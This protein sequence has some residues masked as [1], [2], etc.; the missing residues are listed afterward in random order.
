M[1]M[2]LPHPRWR[3]HD[4][5]RMCIHHSLR[6]ICSQ[7][8]CR[9][10]SCPASSLPGGL[11]S[12]IITCSC[13]PLHHLCETQHA[14]SPTLN[15]APQVIAQRIEHAGAVIQME[16]KAAYI[17]RKK[18]ARHAKPLSP[19]N[20]ENGGGGEADTAA[21][22]DGAAAA[23]GSDVAAE[24][25]A[26]AMETATAADGAAAAGGAAAADGAAAAKPAAA[27][28]GKP[29]NDYEISR[30]SIVRVVLEGGAVEGLGF[31]AVREAFG[32]RE[33]GIRFVDFRLVST[34]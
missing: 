13:V 32:G 11:P 15:P 22:A 24:P 34:L 7:L 8:H 27:A 6:P 30:N 28:G 20:P 25:L 10:C 26:T 33:G 5:A 21:A 14:C 12:S 4:A 19:H 9:G 16:P 2:K 18:D 29:A 1:D 23:A 3:S 31:G 17:A